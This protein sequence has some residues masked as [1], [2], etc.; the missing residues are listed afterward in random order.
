MPSA[1]AIT[2]SIGVLMKPRTSSAFAPTY[3][4]VTMTCAF[5]LRGYWRALIERIAWSPAMTMTRL[6]TIAMTGRRMKRSV[7]FMVSSRCSGASL[8]GR[9]RGELRNGGAVAVA[10]L[11]RAAAHHRLSRVQSGDHRD[12]VPPALSRADEL[13]P[14]DRGRLPGLVLLL[15]DGEH[16]VPVGREDHRRRGDGQHGSLL[17]RDDLHGREQPGAKAPVVVGERG[18][19]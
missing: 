3:A 9:L 2:R 10:Q 18:P 16:R 7:S 14:R 19:D 4:V 11:E 1:D 17:R 12:D 15:L 6:T 13:L 8:L 5:S